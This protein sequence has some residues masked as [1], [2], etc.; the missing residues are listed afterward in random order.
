[1]YTVDEHDEVVELAEVPPASAGAPMPVVMADDRRVLLAYL[2]Q[3][4]ELW[5]GGPLSA[6][7]A[8]AVEEAAAIAEFIQPRSHS[9]GSP[10][11]EALHGHPLH[12]RGLQPYGA[13]EVRKSS[14]VRGLE[15]RNRVHSAHDPERFARL[16]H[17]VFTFH[18]S[19]FECVAEGL[20]ISQHAE[21]RARLLLEMQ[22]RLGS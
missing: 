6:D 7:E 17:Y 1:M 20:R 9:F 4:R 2:V 12:A 18:D 19:T 13:Y 10:N 3:Q 11:D 21:S 5:M 22:R 16:R 15:R 14:W 8:D